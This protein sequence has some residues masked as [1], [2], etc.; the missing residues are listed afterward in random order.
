MLDLQ[1]RLLIRAEI[2]TTLIDYWHNVDTEWGN[3]AHEY[4]TADGTFENTAG[5]IRTGREDVRDFYT[6]RQNRGPRI[7]RHVIANLKVD[8]HDRMN[9]TSQWILLLYAH[10]GEPVLRSEPAILIGDVIDVSVR[11]A[12]GRWRYKSRVI[13]ALFKSDTPT[14][15]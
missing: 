1:E 6:G 12:D 14:T 13:S 8:V 3:H 15:T 7:A 5:R 10:D 2:E 11:E 9:A 4:Y